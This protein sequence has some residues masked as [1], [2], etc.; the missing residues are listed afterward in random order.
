MAPFQGVTGVVF[1]SVFTTY[2]AGVDKLFTPFFTGVLHRLT[3]RQCTE[4]AGPVENGTPVVPQVLSKDANEIVRFSQECAS[5][6]FGEINWNLGCPYPQ[7][8]NKKRGSGMMPYPEMVNEI[9]EQAMPRMATSLSVKCR[10]GYFSADEIDAMMPVFN[11]Y[12]LSELIIHPRIGRQLYTGAPDRGAFAKAAAAAVMPVAYNGDIFSKDDS[13]HFCKSNP[14]ITTLM[15]GRGLLADP[16]L[17]ADIKGLTVTADRQAYIRKFLDELYFA[18]RRHS[19]DRLTSLGILKEYWQY[20]SGSFDRPHEVFRILKRVNDFGEYE[21]AVKRVFEE[22]KWA[23]AKN[24]Q[25]S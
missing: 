22:F 17:P 24:I 16:F 1:R 14:G 25:A 5:L 8:A 11:H 9:L 3:S 10:V 15:I 19:G 20:V 7:V 6:G 18:T 12:P 21:D 13:L 4:L 23:G 2:F